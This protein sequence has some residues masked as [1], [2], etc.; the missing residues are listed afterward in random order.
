M[1]MLVSERIIDIL[2]SYGSR[3]ILVFML[4]SPPGAVEK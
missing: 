4:F 3:E 2:S 1:A